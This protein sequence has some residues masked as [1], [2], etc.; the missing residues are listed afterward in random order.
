VRAAR[1]AGLLLLLAV[2]SGCALRSEPPAWEQPAPP[3]PDTPV[4]QEGALHRLELDNGLSILVLEDH[5]LPRVVLAVTVRRGEG[6]VDPVQAG[7]APFTAE[8]M[9]RGAGDRGAL[10]LARAVDELGA[11]LA[12]A[13]DWDSITVEV[14]GLS[15]DFD[16]LLEIL[17]DVVLR[18]RFERAE[19]AKAR[20]ETLAA[21]ESAKDDPATLA[22]WNVA[23][24][25]YGEH[26]YGLPLEGT[27]ES[28][29]RLDAA[30]ARAF[31]DT[32][33]LPNDAILSASG[34]VESEALAEAAASAFGTWQPGAPA[35]PGP[36]PPAEAP[37][38]RRIVVVDRPDLVQA[39]IA[40]SHD[41]IARTD[42]E[43]IAAA[44]MNTVLGSGGFSSRLMEV[45]RSEAGLTYGIYSGFSLRRQPGPFVI[46][47]FTRVP[48]SRR[49]IDM[50]L[51]EVER[52]R[53]SEPPTEDEVREAGALSIGQFGLSLETSAAV[54]AALVDLEVHGLPRDSLDTYRSRV[55]AV[56]AADA[57]EQARQRL[58]PGRAAIAV[59]GPAS[60]LVPQL[61]DLGP[62]EVVEP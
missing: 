24:A 58:H 35:E 46:A 37:P 23:R 28:V 54:M 50:V 30:V 18:P 25:V 14:S 12:V 41:G 57:A 56:T 27:P 48:E 8:L 38:A 13:S 19:A 26:R 7:L 15:R 60:E 52:Y 42:P 43:R 39:Q 62:V 36:P 2:A 33:F 34:D 61:E 29:A 16:Q 5:R 31:H 22:R 32:V 49:V 11:T 59:V 55:R 40:L 44:V 10:A 45:I 9:K 53:T 51:A 6:S 20:S 1:R 47:T 4:V 21:L 17:A 3:A